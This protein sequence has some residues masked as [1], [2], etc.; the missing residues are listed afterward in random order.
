MRDATRED[1]GLVR[2]VDADETAAGPVGEPCRPRVQPE[3]T[4][5][6]RG[7][8]VAR[9]LLADVELATRRRV[10]RLSDTDHRTED[11][12]SALVERRPH[13]A[14]TDRQPRVDRLEGGEPSAR[15]PTGRPV[16]KDREPDADPG[17][18]VPVLHAV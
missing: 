12:P 7:R 13:T 6:V 2:P 8:V 18:P 16:R 4:W 1:L 3:G 10:L 14:V 17:L 11:R 5:P 9:E 15:H